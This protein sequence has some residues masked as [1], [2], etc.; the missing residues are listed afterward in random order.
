MEHTNWIQ[1]AGWVLG[2]FGAAI[3][4]Y[5]GLR[6]TLVKLE[7]KI[8]NLEESIHNL[9][10]DSRAAEGRLIHRIESNESRIE[11]IESTYFRGTL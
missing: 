3:G 4:A 6:V 1:L 2:P 9:K 11:R 10:E 5:L 7:T 8:S